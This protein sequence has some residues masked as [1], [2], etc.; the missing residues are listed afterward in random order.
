LFREYNR[1]LDRQIYFPQFHA[2][3]CQTDHLSAEGLFVL[4]N[5]HSFG[6]H[7]DNTLMAWH[8]NF[9]KNWHKIKDAYDERF[10]RMWTY[11]LL[12]CA[13]SF[14]SRSNQLWQIVFSKD[15][16]EGSYQRIGE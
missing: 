8:S 13:G 6:A 14:R 7:Y 16:V 12:S 3:I 2:S 11:C 4:E 9:E 15:G 5:W 1:S 10:Y